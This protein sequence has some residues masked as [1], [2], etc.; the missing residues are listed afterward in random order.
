MSSTTDTALSH[1][2]DTPSDRFKGPLSYIL[3]GFSLPVY[4]RYEEQR[5]QV[6]NND[7]VTRIACHSPILLPHNLERSTVNHVR[8][9]P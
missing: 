6:D 3:T 1:S 4:S 7:H 8:T 2:I 5:E 9:R